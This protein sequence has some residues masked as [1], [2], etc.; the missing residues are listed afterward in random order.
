AGSTH[1]VEERDAPW[2]LACEVPFSLW[3]EVPDRR[4]RGAKP[5]GFSMTGCGTLSFPYGCTVHS[6]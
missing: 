3:G 4:E 1:N 6:K 5:N 2:S